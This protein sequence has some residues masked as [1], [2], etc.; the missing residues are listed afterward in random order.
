MRTLAKSIMVAA[1]FLLAACEHTTPVQQQPEA[2]DPQPPSMQSQR[3]SPASSGSAPAQQQQQGGEQE[4]VVITLHLAQQQQEDELVP[5]DI[6]GGN[7]LHALPQP[8]II[9]SDMGRVTPVRQGEDEIYLLLEMNERGIPKLRAVT[10]QAQG[11]F[12]LL[13]VQGQLV[14]VSQITQA[15]T[16]GRLVMAT[17]GPEHA[18]GILRLMQGS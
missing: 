4:Q 12:L 13:S 16:D 3:S 10:E 2:V 7:T 17:E 8:V 6:G 9:Q 14:N 15:I 1:A 11:H 5:V 18:Q